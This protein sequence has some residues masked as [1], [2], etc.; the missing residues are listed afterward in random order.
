M[1]IKKLVVVMVVALVGVA[2]AIRIDAVRK[3]IGLPPV[4]AV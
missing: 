1:D 2:I 4:S 3:I